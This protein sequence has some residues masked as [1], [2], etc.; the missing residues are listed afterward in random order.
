MKRNDILIVVVV[1]IVT[2]V[3]SI[4]LANVLFGGGKRYTLTAPAVEP[5]SADFP[6]PDERYFNSYALNPTKN[7]TIGDSNNKDPFREQ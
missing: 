4:L 5:I 2:G 7:I 6:K 3:I 1:G